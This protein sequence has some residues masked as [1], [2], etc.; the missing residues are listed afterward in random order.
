MA[1][2]V[3]FL[4][5]SLYSFFGIR[6]TPS[7]AVFNNG[8]Q[9]TTVNWITSPH[10]YFN[11]GEF[12]EQCFA[13]FGSLIKSCHIK[14]VILKEEFTFQLKESACGDGTLDLKK[15]IGL[16]EQIAPDMPVIIEHLRSDE[17]YLESLEYVKRLSV[18]NC[19]IN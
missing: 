9:G 4:I 11:N 8:K 14:D 6:N 13:A 15:Y 19:N 10:K 16:A 2:K 17:E 7:L 1:I 12:M 5:R 18:H 3:L